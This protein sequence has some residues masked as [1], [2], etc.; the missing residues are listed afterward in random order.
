MKGGQEKGQLTEQTHPLHIPQLLPAEQ[1]VLK[2]EAQ[3]CLHFP[4]L[5]PRWTD[6][7]LAS[8]PCIHRPFSQVS[9]RRAQTSVIL[10]NGLSVSLASPGLHSHLT[11]VHSSGLELTGLPPSLRLIPKGQNRGSMPA[12]IHRAWLIWGFPGRWDFP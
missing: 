12:P 2:T 3:D 7:T 6:F 1:A 4:L 9:V 5:D 11:S 10:R 8:M